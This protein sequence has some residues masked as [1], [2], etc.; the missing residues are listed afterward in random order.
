[1]ART[2]YP[3]PGRPC[4]SQRAPC[5]SAAPW[6]R[7]GSAR[8]R[9]CPAFR[10][11]VNEL[12]TP[13][14]A[15][16]IPRPQQGP[17]SPNR[18]LSS[19]PPSLAPRGRPPLASLL[20]T[21]NPVV[22]TS[23]APPPRFWPV[24]RLS[25]GPGAVIPGYLSAKA[26]SGRQRLPRGPLAAGGAALLSA[27]ETPR[28]TSLCRCSQ[29]RKHVTVGAKTRSVTDPWPIRVGSPLS[30]HPGR[31]SSYSGGDRR[32]LSGFPL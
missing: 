29:Q 17:Y 13:R 22:V 7:G 30:G 24:P 31:C 12:K 11:V 4:P 21:D 26:G 3:Q 23:V 8:R 10:I 6:F 20:Q 25:A 2:C 28:A 32:V 9:G 15:L 14:K 27:P 1:M 19:E 16:Q 18:S 5:A